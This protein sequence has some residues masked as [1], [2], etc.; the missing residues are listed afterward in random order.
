MRLEQPDCRTEQLEEL[1]VILFRTF[2]TEV[3]LKLQFIKSICLAAD[4]VALRCNATIILS[5]NSTNICRDV[6]VYTVC[7]VYIGTF[8]NVRET[9]LLNSWNTRLLRLKRTV[10]YLIN[11]F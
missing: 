9:E 2:R 5:S 8:S 10:N 6:F 3:F 4:S 1:F 11:V 7:S